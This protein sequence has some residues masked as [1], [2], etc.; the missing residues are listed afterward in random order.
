MADVY[1]AAAPGEEDKARGLADAL[2]TLGFDAEA[3]AP[4]ENDVKQ[5]TDGAKAV[6]LI[7]SRAANSAP[8]FMALSMLA[9]DR[10]KLVSAEAES[11]ATPGP[12]Q[13]APRIDL[14]VRDRTQFKARFQALI[15]ELDKLA[16][17]KGEEK[18]MPDALSKARAALLKPIVPPKGSQARKV[19]IFMAAVV[20]LFAVGFG[21]GR[22]IQAVRAG[23]FSLAPPR[24]EASTTSAPV[25]A[26][27]PARITMAELERQPWREVVARI[28]AD[29]GES[30]QDGAR[31]GD[32]LDQTLACLAHLGGAEGFLPSPVSA[33]EQCDAAA[34]QNN[35]AGLYFSWVL[36]REAPH[37]ELG[38]AEA[39]ARLLRA[40]ELGWTPALIDY[41]QLLGPGQQAEAGRLFLAAAEKN[42]PRGQF[43]YARWLRDS[44]AGPR[45]PAAAIPYLDRAARA[46]QLDAAHMLATLYRD[47]IG[48]ERNATRARALYEQA[49][50]GGHSAAMFNLA[51]MLRTGSEQ[52]RARAIALYRDLACMS[53]ERQIQPM[54]AA[55]L[56]A[57]QESAACR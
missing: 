47:G 42:D 45:D 25:E 56:R 9:F 21:A 15:V 6:L 40:A 33:R 16:P 24:A 2:K 46:G 41:G 30:I 31:R 5:L 17:T 36:H 38:E 52:D 20:A 55:R 32:A 35:A 28:D 8:W 10:K 7:W 26:Q 22:V 50:R 11:G 39:R 27:A 14:A 34:A 48:A 12:F 53:D 37:A 19:G 23:D 3:G 4:K 44:P 43:A 57:L 18:A 29:A 49:A 51:D 13:T 1:V 54:A